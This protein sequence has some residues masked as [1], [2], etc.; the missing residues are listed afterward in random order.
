MVAGTTLN[1][2]GGVVSPTPA[3]GPFQ[4]FGDVNVFSTTQTAGVLMYGGD[5]NVHGGSVFAVNIGGE[6]N[7]FD[8]EFTI[9]RTDNSTIRM[10][11]GFI[12][13]LDQAFE[14]QVEILGGEIDVF[15]SPGG[16]EIRIRDGTI[17]VF[18]SVGGASIFMTGGSVERTSFF[19]NSLM[20]VSGGDLSSDFNAQTGAELH[21]I[22]TDF[23]LNGQP[24][25]G[26]SPGQ[27]IVVPQRNIAISG[28]LLDGNAVNLFLSTDLMSPQFFSG[29]ATLRLTLVPETATL[30]LAI[31][32]FCAVMAIRPKRDAAWN[33]LAECR[34][35][36]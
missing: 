19:F 10:Y 5:L 20:E 2:D 24:I 22:G 13:H 28:T 11:G 25:P 17:G 12:D 35:R 34:R 36:C 4:T 33:T 16:S 32:G 18:D 15:F 29:N 14:S 3:Q 26:F 7:I 8:G 1:V 30:F 21:L 6:V 9:L 31:P 27:S 23:Q